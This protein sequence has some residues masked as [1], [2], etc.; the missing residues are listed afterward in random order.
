MDADNGTLNGKYIT[1][2]LDQQNYGVHINNIREIIGMVP[3]TSIPKTPEFV[4]GVINIRGKIIPVIDLRERMG[5]SRQEYD[6]RTPIIIAELPG[7]KGQTHAGVIVDR[8]SEV[9]EGSESNIADTPSFGINV[10]TRFFAGILKQDDSM[11]TLINIDEVLSDIDLNQVVTE[12][13]QA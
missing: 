11:T 13:A 7:T 4:Q 2:S 10:D 9:I 5:L 12:Q 6:S 1:F 3:I 8:V